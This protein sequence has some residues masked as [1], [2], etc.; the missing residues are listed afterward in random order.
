MVKEWIIITELFG[1]LLVTV[2]CWKDKS[3]LCYQCSSKNTDENP[4]CDKTNFKFLNSTQLDDLKFHCT[5]R[6]S[7]FCFIME[8]K[9]AGKLK[10]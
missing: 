10:Q 7:D 3:T 5:R 2:D 8:E 6:L 1:L 4:V 9:E